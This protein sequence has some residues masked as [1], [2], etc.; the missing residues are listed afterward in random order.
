[1]G[2][3]RQ[4][5]LSEEGGTEAT[6]TQVLRLVGLCPRLSLLALAAKGRSCSTTIIRSSR[7]A[8]VGALPSC[9]AAT[10]TLASALVSRALACHLSPPLSPCESEEKFLKPE[11]LQRPARRWSMRVGLLCTRRNQPPRYGDAN[12]S[13]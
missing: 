12:A 13:R 11:T 9:I 5:E 3:Y 7:I 4:L 8:D 6:A 1:M 2:C 10:E